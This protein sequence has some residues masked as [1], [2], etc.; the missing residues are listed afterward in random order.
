MRT[1]DTQGLPSSAQPRL[2]E[3]SWTAAAELL[4]T[5]GLQ[6]PLPW[7]TGHRAQ[8]F[9]WIHKNFIMLSSLLLRNFEI[10]HIKKFKD[11]NIF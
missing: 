7:L 10:F 2:V 4:R 8:S 1:A 5:L 6:L 9:Y 11:K 3:G